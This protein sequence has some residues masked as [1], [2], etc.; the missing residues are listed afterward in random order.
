MLNQR[1]IC[2]NVIHLLVHSQDLVQ[3]QGHAERKTGQ[4]K[5]KEDHIVIHNVQTLDTDSSKDRYTHRHRNPRKHLKVFYGKTNW[6][7][8]KKKFDSYRKV[9]R[10]SEE[11]SKDYLM[12]SLEGKALDFLT[13]TKINLEKIFF[14]K[15]YEKASDQIWRE[16]VD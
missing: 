16:R 14:Q 15:N 8:F 10:W 12:W 3:G 6:L 11:E 4:R 1:F 5:Q 13:V 7:Y 9:M 2:T